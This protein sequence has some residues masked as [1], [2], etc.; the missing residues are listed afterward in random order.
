MEDEQFLNDVFLISGKMVAQMTTQP[1]S[2]LQAKI[3]TYGLIKSYFM[4]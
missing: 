3:L 4:L 2:H 1:P